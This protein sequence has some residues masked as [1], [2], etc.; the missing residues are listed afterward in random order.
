MIIEKITFDPSQHIPNNQRFPVLIY[1]QISS[2][3]DTAT[4][5][6]MFSENGWTGI[7]R[8]GVFD[9]HHYHSGAHE[10]LGIGRGHATLQIGGP[11]GR[12]L[13]VSLGDCLILPAGTGHMRLNSSADF[14]VVGGY[15]PGQ[16]ADIQTSAPTEDTLV[17]IRALPKPKT[18]P[19]NGLAGGLAELW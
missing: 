4:F 10:V 9:Y 15:P 17:R 6:A 11:D 18:D 2:H 8:N 12:R 5:E 7:W 14:Q 3:P 13:D 19:V 1:R 16:Q